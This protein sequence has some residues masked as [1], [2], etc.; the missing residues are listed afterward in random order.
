MGTATTAAERPALTARQEQLFRW[1]VRFWARHLR[2]P[3]YRDVMAG[4]R[5][6]SPNGVACHLRAL[7]KKGYLEPPDTSARCVMPA[8]LRE[9]LVP[10]VG[11]VA[12]K[13]LA[14]RLNGGKR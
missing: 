4:M 2:P 1:V 7:V 14:D 13:Y 5:I 8:G 9:R 11:P 12:E 3:T 6:N 10:A